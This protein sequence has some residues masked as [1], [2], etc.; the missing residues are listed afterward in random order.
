MENLNQKKNKKNVNNQKKKKGEE[1]HHRTITHF[2]ISIK[3]KF[4]TLKT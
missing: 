2:F 3:W 1:V 4:K